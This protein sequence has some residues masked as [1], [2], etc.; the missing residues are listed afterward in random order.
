MDIRS[1]AP[2]Y[3]A[4]VYNV[5]KSEKVKKN[6]APTTPT[7]GAGEKVEISNT[8]TEIRKVLETAK[9]LPEIRIAMVDEIRSRIKNNDYPLERKLY[10]IMSKLMDSK[11]L[12]PY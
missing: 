2:G 9:E 1:V 7:S 4:Q 11:V 5:D 10:D 6:P 3:A 8:S 12:L